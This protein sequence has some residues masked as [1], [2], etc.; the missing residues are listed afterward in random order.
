MFKGLVQIYTGNSKGK[1]TAALG[2]SLR[3]IGHGYNV[4]FMQFMKGS[5]YYGEIAT[6]NKLSDKI[7][8]A[9]FGR[10]CRNGGLIKAGLSTCIACGDCFIKQGEDI[11]KDK[12]EMEKALEFTIEIIQSQKYQIVVLDEILNC[13]YFDLITKKQL[14][15]ILERKPDNV[16]LVLTGRNAPDDI[17]AKADL[18]TDMGQIKHPFEKGVMARRGIEY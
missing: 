1:T 18:V 15:D 11:T 14:L 4:Y 8:H 7:K 10:P 16:E 5:N 12:E 3:A 13:L 6:L 9:Q 2:L 17:I